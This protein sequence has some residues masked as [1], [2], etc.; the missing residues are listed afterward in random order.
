VKIYSYLYPRCGGDEALAEELTQQ[1]F[2]RAI[3]RRETYEGRSNVITWLC[4]IARNKLADHYRRVDRDERRHLRLVVRELP[5]AAGERATS[6]VEDREVIMSALRVLPASQRAAVVLC[7]IDGLSV[8]ET[9][10]ALSRS[11]SATESLLTRAR[12]RLRSALRGSADD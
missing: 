11:E 12:E 1:T 10:A 8:R 2:I 5:I 9:A 7:Y 6:A 4:S 3:E